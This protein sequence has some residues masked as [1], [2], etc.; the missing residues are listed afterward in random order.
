VAAQVSQPVMG[1]EEPG[2]ELGGE[3]ECQHR[4]D[5]PE[6]WAGAWFVAREPD[7]Q[8]GDRE[9]RHAEFPGDVMAVDERQVTIANAATVI[10]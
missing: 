8:V 3:H 9:R 2:S 10:R 6:R 7:D 4:F 1:G 5:Q